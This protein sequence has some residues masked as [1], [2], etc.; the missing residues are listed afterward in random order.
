VT[1]GIP[2]R[3]AEL[4]LFVLCALVQAGGGV[5]PHTGSPKRKQEAGDANEKVIIFLSFV[6]CFGE[7]SAA[8]E[9]LCFRSVLIVMTD[10]I[11]RRCQFSEAISILH[12][13][14]KGHLECFVNIVQI[15][16]R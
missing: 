5:V 15:C 14:L 7:N 1:T 11:H 2:S 8:R 16:K 13:Y 9:C 6:V 4:S 3:D 10:Q 12:Q